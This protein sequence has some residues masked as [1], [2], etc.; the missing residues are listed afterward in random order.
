MGRDPGKQRHQSAF[1][2]GAGDGPAYRR[3]GG[4]V[5][6]Y[7]SD[8]TSC[9]V[10]Q[11]PAVQLSQDQRQRIKCSMPH[12][13]LALLSLIFA[14]MLAR[15]S[16]ARH[17]ALVASCVGSPW[18]LP[19]QITAYMLKTIQVNKFCEPCMMGKVKTKQLQDCLDKASCM[20]S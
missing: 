17:S 12:A 5:N 9:R 7:N 8:R 11:P 13:K 20:S 1:S 15:C 10:A 3:S 18:S 16:T 2:F 19:G 14:L 4:G 6:L